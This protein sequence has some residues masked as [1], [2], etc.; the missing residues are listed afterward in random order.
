M[1]VVERP[2]QTMDVERG[3]EFELK[4]TVKQYLNIVTSSLQDTSN[5]PDTHPT[6]RDRKTPNGI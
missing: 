2:K 6:L 4:T 3:G 1:K 5:S